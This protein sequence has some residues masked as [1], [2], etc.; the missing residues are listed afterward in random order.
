MGM[1]APSVLLADVES[2]IQSLLATGVEE[3]S[4][5]TEKARMIRLA[6]LRQMR[7]DLLEEVNAASGGVYRLVQ[8]VDV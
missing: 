2:Q 5:G 4:A 6:E 1:V 3:Y 7:R 8:P